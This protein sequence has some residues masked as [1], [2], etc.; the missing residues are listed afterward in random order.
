MARR[1]GVWPNGPNPR[2][3]K[4]CAV[5]FEKGRPD[6]MRASPRGQAAV[7]AAEGVPAKP[8]HRWLKRGDGWDEEAEE[9]ERNFSG[10]NA[11][12]PPRGRDEGCAASCGAQGT[13]LVDPFGACML[14]TAP[15]PALGR[16]SLLRGASPCRDRAALPL[17]LQRGPL[18]QAP[19]P[20]KPHLLA[21][22]REQEL[23]G[24]GLSPWDYSFDRTAAVPSVPAER[25]TDLPRGEPPGTAPGAA[26]FVI[27]TPLCSPVVSP[28]ASAA[29]DPP[30]PGP[31]A[32]DAKQRRGSC[33]CQVPSLND[34]LD[35]PREDTGMD[36]VV[37]RQPSKDEEPG[38]DAEDWA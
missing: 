37:A 10:E 15:G 26:R 18:A 32:G 24:E 21:G 12:L 28:Q 29:F 3:G 23:P 4:P 7:G 11:G 35:P 31:E 30:R 38:E 33:D 8:G 20:S 13:S 17:H 1:G 5:V 19:A 25:H 9:E 36:F 14:T 27:Y 6:V 22:P 2:G 34:C 16:G